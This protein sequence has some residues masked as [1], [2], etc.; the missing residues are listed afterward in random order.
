LKY[1]PEWH[2]ARRQKA[3]N[4]NRLLK[5]IPQITIPFVHDYNY[6]IYHQYT[7]L[8]E[9]REGLKNHLKSKEVGFDTYYPLPLHLQECYR[10]LK[11]KIGD[12]P[13]SEKLANLAI[14]LPVFP[15]LGDQE[16]EYVAESIEE[17]Y[18][19]S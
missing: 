13:V 10:D 19:K 7:I 12:L 14:S 16:Q 8:A 11:Y 17:F 4:Y 3:A 18:R 2:E 9:N 6:H 15:E 1:L 5:N